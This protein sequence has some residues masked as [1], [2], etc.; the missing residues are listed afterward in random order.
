VD[1]NFQAWVF[2]KQAGPLKFT[3][4]QMAWL[5]MMKEHIAR[6]IHIGK[7][8]LDFAPFDASGGLGK[9]W[10]LFGE[11]TDEIMNEINEALAA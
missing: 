8:D 11:K 3:N 7:D 4:E 1:R 5:R 9:M 6:S 10:Q 2:Q